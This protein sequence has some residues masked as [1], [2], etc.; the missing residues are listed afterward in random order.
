MR[1]AVAA[2]H[3]RKLFHLIYAAVGAIVLVE[4]QVELLPITRSSTA[5]YFHW[6]WF[7]VLVC[8][9]HPF[10]N[11]QILDGHSETLFLTEHLFDPSSKLSRSREFELFPGFERPF[12]G[13]PLK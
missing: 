1:R 13:C 5:A 3:R 8:S 6:S 7:D 10:L 4:Q 9:S 12:W 11:H 2:V